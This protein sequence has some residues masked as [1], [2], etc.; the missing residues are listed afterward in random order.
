MFKNLVTLK[1]ILLLSE[2]Y[3][4]GKWSIAFLF[5]VIVALEFT[6]PSEYLFG[7]LYTGPILLANSRLSRFGK[8]QIT[9]LAVALTLLNLFV[10][11]RETIALATV[12]NRSIAVLALGVTGYLSDRNQQ[13][14]ETISIA[15]AQLQSQEQLASFR[16]DFVST[17]S[18]DLKTPI[19]GAIETINAFG[20]SKFGAVTIAQQKVLETMARSHKMTLQ[21]VETMLDIYRNDTEGLKLQIAPVNL[22]ALAEEVIATLIDLSAARRVYIS[23]SYGNSDFRRSLWVNGDAVQLQRVFTNLLTNGINHS[24][25]GGRVEVVMEFYS[26]YQIVKVIDR[27]LGIVPEELPQLFDRFYQGKGDRQAKGSG[28]GLYLSRQIIEAHGGIIWAENQVPHGA[29]FGFRLPA[30]SE[31]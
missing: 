5:A 3:L 15:K 9:M 20:Q 28:L 1:T 23:M 13:Y 19:L 30:I 25:R 12:A 16:E 27:G 11:Y 26:S 2:K 29:L 6:T 31:K 8:L 18:H 22:A 14:Q 10:P 4:R 7:Y 17:L 21:L 24:P